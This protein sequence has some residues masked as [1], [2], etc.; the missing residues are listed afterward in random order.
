MSDVS[1]EIGGVDEDVERRE[2][3]H[4]GVLWRRE[5]RCSDG[6]SFASFLMSTGE[7]IGMR[8][9]P[10]GISCA[11]PEGRGVLREQMGCDVLEDGGSARVAR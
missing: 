7:A 8:L 6:E 1:D 5:V 4:V 9:P 3:V 10:C 2:D 11:S